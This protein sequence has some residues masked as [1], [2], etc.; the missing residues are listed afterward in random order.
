MS[1]VHIHAAVLACPKMFDWKLFAAD[2]RCEKCMWSPK[3]NLSFSFYLCP[4]ISGHA[5]CPPKYS[6][7][8]FFVLTCARRPIVLRID[9]NI[10]ARCKWCAHGNLRVL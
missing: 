9:H 4:S 1:L 10:T 2:Y 3:S 5:W 8:S 6:L 7:P